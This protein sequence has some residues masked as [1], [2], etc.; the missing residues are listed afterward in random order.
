[1]LGKYEA[2]SDTCSLHDV[3]VSVREFTFPRW[4]TISAPEGFLSTAGSAI[5]VLI[6]SL[7]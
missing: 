1:M 4:E 6:V 5:S 7:N 2:C 3:V